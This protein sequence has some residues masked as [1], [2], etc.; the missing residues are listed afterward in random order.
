MTCASGDVARLVLFHLPHKTDKAIESIAA[1][2]AAPPLPG[3]PTAGPPALRSSSSMSEGARLSAIG[4]DLP[5]APSVRRPREH[6]QHDALLRM[7][8]QALRRFEQEYAAA[9]RGADRAAWRGA[10]DKVSLRGP[11]A[12]TPPSPF[13][14]RTRAC[15]GCGGRRGIDALRSLPDLR[16][17]ARQPCAAAGYRWVHVECV[18]RRWRA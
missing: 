12:P 9:L 14:S 13:C 7:M 1:G 16:R 15:S 2:S 18:G 4:V 17:D 11:V 5:H 3:A 8:H 6:M 10:M